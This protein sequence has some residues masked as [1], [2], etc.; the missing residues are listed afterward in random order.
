MAGKY[1][2]GAQGSPILVATI[3]AAGVLLLLEAIQHQ[4]PDIIA[5]FQQRPHAAFA[6]AVVVALILLL[7][8]NTEPAASGES[9]DRA[10]TRDGQHG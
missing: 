3:A 5:I 8:E 4:L 10:H 9:I 1:S 6:V 2:P 7:S